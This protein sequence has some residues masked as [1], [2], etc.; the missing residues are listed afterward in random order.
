MMVVNNMFQVPTRRQHR[1]LA[2][3]ALPAAPRLLRAGPHRLPDKGCQLLWQVQTQ[4][5]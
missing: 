5:Q 3:L 4:W 1:R 2:A